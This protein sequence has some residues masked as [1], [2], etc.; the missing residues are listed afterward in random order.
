MD[1]KNKSKPSLV[2]RILAIIVAVLLGVSPATAVADMQGIDVSSC[3]MHLPSRVY[4]LGVLTSLHTFLL[5]GRQV[6]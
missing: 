2:M 6:A 3:L 5:E 4:V 1:I